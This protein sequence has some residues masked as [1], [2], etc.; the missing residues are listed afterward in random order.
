MSPG[1]R[2]ESEDPRA[3]PQA[4]PGEDRDL[5][6]TA[7]RQGPGYSEPVPPDAGNESRDLRQPR[8][9]QPGAHRA[10]PAH[11]G[12]GGYAEPP[13]YP[14]PAG[15]GDPSAYPAP[16]GYGDPSAYPATEDYSEASVHPAPGGYGD[17]SAYPA[18]E[19]Y[20]EASV[21]PA[22]GGYGDPSAY[23]PAEGYG[24]PAEGY[25]EAAD[26]GEPE[27][28]QPGGHSH[29]QDDEGGGLRA[30]HAAAAG[31][32]PGPGSGQELGHDYGGLWTPDAPRGFGRFRRHGRRGAHA[33]ASD[34]HQPP[35]SQGTPQR[36]YVATGSSPRTLRRNA[37]FLIGAAAVA[38]IAAVVAAVLLLGHH[39]PSRAS[40]AGSG[41]HPGASRTPSSAPSPSLEPAAPRFGASGHLGVPA[42]IAGLRLN[43]QLTFRF[44]GPSVRRQDANSFFI[45]VRDV[46]SGFYTADPA[47]ATFTAKDRRIMFITAYLAGTGNVASALHGFMN[48]HT[49]Y[50]QRQVAAGPLGGAA[51]CGYLPQQPAPVAHCMWADHNT[52]ADFYAWNSSPTALAQTMLAIRPHIEVA[53][54]YAG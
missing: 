1:H 25:G 11:Q 13:V 40:A 22:P 24:Q 47:A 41:H 21:H 16:A 52:Y 43:Q 29:L 5:D 34:T 42:Q 50:G 51:A 8:G 30:G 17:P 19:D 38:V 48:N 49:F 46:V 32:H 33:P 2:S 45:P 54:P 44:V 3:S 28:Y 4:G 39:G 6:W 10:P 36:P 7:W 23:P 9:R 37:G 20:S 31:N 12:G 53:H 15:Y 26:Y 18:T 35:A 27:G 14:A